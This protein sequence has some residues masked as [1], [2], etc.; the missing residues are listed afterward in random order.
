[1]IT[2]EEKQANYRVQFSRLKKAMGNSFFL[3]AVFIEYA[4][5]EDRTESIL[6]YEGNEIV[7]K[8]EKDFITFRR[9]SNRIKHLATNKESIISR[10][11]SDDL[12]DRIQEWVGGRN[13][14]VHGLLKRHSTTE[15]LKTFAEVGEKLCKELSNRSNNY[16]RMIRRK[17]AANNQ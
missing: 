6:L 16:K 10:Y 8:N 14:V 17:M 5:I 11:F 4:I 2:N 7:P 1:M 15:E 9:K 13:S 12:M 3:E